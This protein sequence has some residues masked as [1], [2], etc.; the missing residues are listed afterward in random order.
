MKLTIKKKVMKLTDY[1]TV[2][3]AKDYAATQDK[4]LFCEYLTDLPFESKMLDSFD[5]KMW[6][7]ACNLGFCKETD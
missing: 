1:L 5:E 4:L 7:Y 3:N 6:I 2:E